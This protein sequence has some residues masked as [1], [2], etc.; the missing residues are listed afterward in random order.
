M[1]CICNLSATGNLGANNEFT[2]DIWEGAIFTY[3]TDSAGALNSIDTTATLDQAYWDAKINAA[4]TLDRFY[5]TPP[6]NNVADER[7]DP[8]TETDNEGNNYIVRDEPRAISFEFIKGGISSTFLGSLKRW[9][10]EK[11]SA[12]MLDAC[13]NLWGKKSADGTTLLPA[14]IKFQ[15]MYAKGV[16]KTGSTVAKNMVQ[17]EWD[18]AD[19]DW[20]GISADQIDV[21]ILELMGL[22]DVNLSNASGLSTTSVTFDAKTAFGPYNNK[23]LVDG[24][25]GLTDWNVFNATSSAS[26]TV[27]TN[28]ESPAGTYTITYVAQTS[29][30]NMEITDNF[31]GFESDTLQYVIP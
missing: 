25:D 8:T 14:P 5:P 22:I 29:T 24:R 30:D 16:R 28:T 9:S 21:D 15:T 2:P 20:A 3:R 11:A 12:F 1:G 13:G 18:M 27:L 17:F 10:C 26:V 23:T 4:N 7:G 19:E 6:I 31:D